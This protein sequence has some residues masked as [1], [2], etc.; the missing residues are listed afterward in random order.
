MN[1]VYRF[2]LILSAC[3]LVVSVV[4]IAM[5]IWAMRNEARQRRFERLIAVNQFR[6]RRITVRPAAPSARARSR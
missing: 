3:A 1:K 4:S 2:R 6:T 5:S